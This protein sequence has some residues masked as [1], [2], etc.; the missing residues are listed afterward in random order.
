MLTP[1]QRAEMKRYI[2]NAKP[3]ALGPAHVAALREMLQRYE[4]LE[5]NERGARRAQERA[6]DL[7][8]RLAGERSASE[9]IRQQ[10]TTWKAHV[11]E[12]QRNLETARRDGMATGIRL[13][14]AEIA[15]LRIALAA[16]RLPWWRK[17]LARLSRRP[18]LPSPPL[19]AD[20]D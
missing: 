12:A 8:A 11:A 1:L 9:A 7:S 17:L 20:D 14:A 4:E 16:A 3:K 13:A 18:A 6:D 5:S 2:D 15:E 10:L 19:P